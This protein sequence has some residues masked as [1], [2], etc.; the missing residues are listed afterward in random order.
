M[1]TLKI[2]FSIVL[3]L[4]AIPLITA[5]FVPSHYHVQTTIVINQPKDSV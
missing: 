4:I 1:K 5:L 2:L 3:I